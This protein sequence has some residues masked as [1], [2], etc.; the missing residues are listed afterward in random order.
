[1]TASQPARA[2]RTEDASVTSPLKISTWSA[3]PSGA[4]AGATRSGVR[5]RKRASWPAARRAATVWAPTNPV[6]PVTRTFIERQGSRTIGEAR[7]CCGRMPFL[8]RLLVR[9]ADQSGGAERS[10]DE[11]V[12]LAGPEEPD[13]VP[14][15]PLDGRTLPVLPERL[16]LSGGGQPVGQA[17]EHEASLG[18]DERGG[19]QWRNGAGDGR[20]PRAREIVFEGA[21]SHGG[22]AVVRG[23]SGGV[24][25]PGP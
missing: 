18:R 15:V 7:N 2:V 25:D 22:R 8:I 24:G 11:T 3:A 5:T 21:P 13:V 23:Q 4:R 6:A 20:G 19:G 16:G 17:G 10:V 1:M 12:D 14:R 9:P